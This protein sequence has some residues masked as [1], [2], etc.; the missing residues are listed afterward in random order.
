MLE[1]VR[2]GAR[3][4]LHTCQNCVPWILTKIES[5]SEWYVFNYRW[6]LSAHKIMMHITIPLLYL[7]TFNILKHISITSNEILFSCLVHYMIERSGRVHW[8]RRKTRFYLRKSR[9]RGFCK[10]DLIAMDVERLHREIFIM[11]IQNMRG[12]LS[13]SWLQWI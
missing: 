13:R 6:C 12:F 1:L 8:C 3:Q 5:A 7:G 4:C 9:T 2:F 11:K 10:Y